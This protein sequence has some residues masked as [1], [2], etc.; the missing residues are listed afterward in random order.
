MTPKSQ[1]AKA[2][3]AL[4]AL[5]LFVSGCTKKRDATLSESEEETIFAISEFGE[6]N[7]ENNSQKVQTDERLTELSLGEASKA[8]AEKGMVAVTDVEVPK[9]LQFMF[10]GLQITGQANRSYPVVFSVDK[11][12]V[13]AYKVVADASE[14]SILEKEL[15]VSKSEVQLQKQLQKTSDNKKVK[16]L[17][18]S[19]KEARA[20]K[21]AQKQALLVP[22]FKYTVKDFGTLN[23]A[24]NALGETTSS[25]RLKASEWADATHIM[26]SNTSTDRLAVGVDPAKR[27]SDLD[28]T[29]VMNNINNKIM[30]AQTLEEQFQISLNLDKNAKV[31]TLLDV[32]A[33]HIFEIGQ[34]GKTVLTD[35]QLQQLKLGSNKSNIRQCPADIV[36]VLPKEE[37]T[38]CI[39]ILRFDVPV[40]YVRPELPIADQDGNQAAEVDFRETTAGKN[41]GLVQIAANVE[42]RKVES[43]NEM[44]P[45]STIRIADIKDK[46]FFFKRTLE[47]A[48]VTTPFPPG[49]AGQLTIVKFELQESRLVIRKADKL[50]EFKTGSND[51]D[52]EEVMNIPV[53]YFK[54]DTKNSDGSDYALV[55]MVP[56]SR[57]DAEFVELDWTNNSLNSDYSPF[58]AV[59]DSCFRSVSDVQTSDV[60][61]RLD[62]GI[63]N[64]SQAYSTGLVGACISESAMPINDYNGVAG[65]QTTA[66]IKERI[67]FKLVDPATNVAFAP[68]VPFRAQNELGYGVWTIGKMN[69]TD[70]GLT[71]REG[72]ETNYSVVHDLRNGKKIVYTVTGLESTVNLDPAIR[73]LYKETARE[74]VDAW[75]FAYKQAF[76][77]IGSKREGR[78]VEIQFAGENG[79]EAKVGDLDKNIIHFENKFNNNHGVLGVSQVGYNPRSGIVVADSLII[80]AGNLQQFVASSQRNLKISQQW[81]DMKKSFRDQALKMAADQAKKA[82]QQG[83]QAIATQE[84]KAQAAAQFTKGLA[85]LLQGSKTAGKAFLNARNMGLASADVKSAVKQMQSLGASTFKYSSPQ[86]E[87]AWIDRVLRKLAENKSMDEQ[88]LQGLVAAEMLAAKEGKLTSAQRLDLQ[89][90]VQL[91]K[92]RAKLNAQFKNAPGCMLTSRDSIARSFANKTFKE[93]LKEELFFDLGHEMGHSQGLTHNFI[94]SFDKA[95]FGNPDGSE[96]KRNYSSIMDYIE[97]GKFQWDGIGS[98]DIHAL[99]ASHLG[100]LEVSPAFKAALEKQGTAAKVLTAGKFISVNTIKS[101]FAKEGWNNFNSRQVSQYL[102][103]YKY[104]TDIHV[105][106]EPQCQRFD[107]GT[108]ATEIVENLIQDYEENYVTNYHSWDRNNFG[109]ASAG[110]AIGASVNIMFSMRQ[111][112]DEMFYKLVLRTA[113]SQEEINDFVNA[114]VKAYVFYNQVIKTPDA[115]AAFKDGSRFQAVPYQYQE[116]NEKGEPTGKVINDVEI[117]EK[118]AIQDLAINEHRIDTVGIEYDKVMAMN[119]L[120]MK[121]YPDYKYY[122][123]SILF[124]FLDFEKYILGMTPERSLFVNTLTAMMLDELQP[125]F[126]NANATLQ[127]IEGLKATITPSMRMYA[128]VYGIL[129]LEASTLRDK[130]NFANFFKVGSSVGRAPTD[131]VVLSQLGVSDKSKTRLSFWA[132]DNA[133]SSG[134]ILEVAAAKNFFLQNA[135]VIEPLLQKLIAAQIQDQFS[136]GKNAE[137]LAKAKAELTAKLNEMNKEGKVVSA[138][139]A[140]ANAAFTIEGQVEGIMALNKLVIVTSLEKQQ[141]KEDA[142]AKLE[143]LKEMADTY[144]QALPLHALNQKTLKPVITASGKALAEQL[145]KPELEAW[146]ETAANL[147][148]GTQLE[149][150][151]G[152]IMKNVEFLSKLTLMTNP[153][154]NR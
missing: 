85:G 39:M 4:V 7:L 12:Y 55:R 80:Y 34:L 147:V 87:S 2:L 117:V 122:S 24:K 82:E 151:Y 77:G 28:R 144:A 105:G 9:R 132:L 96:S 145:K 119:F 17:L 154:Y 59:H 6:L 78:Y 116:V 136:G 90:S 54:H 94:A 73:E 46:E 129:N 25:L 15:A 128:G 37:Q 137:G 44:D 45:R 104:C 95:N 143:K 153:E 61:M 98:Y 76:A 36:Q 66:R 30:T 93:A 22:I 126:T 74:V 111:F 70:A 113:Q 97:P 79:I 42:P 51:T 110:R 57:N 26:I 123:Q 60:D 107:F 140:K 106:Y 72:Q 120:T 124:S 127:P 142:D 62:K 47:D 20:Q 29:F 150:S 103:P 149:V 65:Y 83:A 16:T 23:R 88:E 31:R 81:A 125:T 21:Q 101:N 92:I 35:S 148:D 64:F 3:L 27:G 102:K 32:D 48:P 63:L 41:V 112:M 131:R 118:K 135:E 99:R 52:Y 50:I 13:T 146:G 67:S 133:I 58:A 139:M 91:G 84:Q 141:G 1:Y 134:S 130:D 68:Q 49:M 114:S 108:S 19:L 121:G 69:P 18:A 138:E 10:K 115:S 40:T 5:T 53:K 43:N 89:R 56:A 14:L 86:A 33:L 71:G 100:L 109:V 11:K 38:N 75:D 8:T 152:I